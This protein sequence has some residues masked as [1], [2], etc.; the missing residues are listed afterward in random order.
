MTLDVDLVLT[1]FEL[2]GPIVVRVHDVDDA[3]VLADDYELSR[4]AWLEAQGQ[5]KNVGLV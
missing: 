4:A 2:I 3:A 1:S 5:T